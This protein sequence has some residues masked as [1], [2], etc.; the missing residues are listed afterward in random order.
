MQGP[1]VFFHF[2]CPQNGRRGLEMVHPWVIRAGEQRSLNS[3][4]DLISPFFFNLPQLSHSLLE[5]LNPFSIFFNH[6]KTLK[7]I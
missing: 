1:A 3:F 4:F 2:G 7:P 6:S 5:F